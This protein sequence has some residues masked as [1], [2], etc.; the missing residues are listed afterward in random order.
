MERETSA[1]AVSSGVID[2]PNGFDPANLP[3]LSTTTDTTTDSIP[4][5]TTLE[6]KMKLPPPSS[7]QPSSSRTT[8]VNKGTMKEISVHFVCF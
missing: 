6:I 2:V 4:V 8:K 1:A 3:S 7:D 5:T